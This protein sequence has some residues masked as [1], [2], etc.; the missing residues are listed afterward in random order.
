MKALI[1]VGGYGTRLRPLTLTVPKP[2]VHFC[3]KSI[4]EHQVEALVLAGVSHI[5]LAVAYQPEAMNSALQAMEK[6][7]NVRITCSREEEPL[8]TAGPIRLAKDLLEEGD[9]ENFFVFNSDVICEFPLK[10]LIDF[11]NAHGKE[12][13]LLVTKVDDPSKYGVVCSDEHGLVQKF[14]EKPKEFVGDCINAGLYIFKKSIINRIEPRPTSIEKE[15]FP[16]MS[17]ESQLF[18]LKLSGYWAD[19][20]QPKDYLRGM[21]LYLHSQATKTDDDEDA[22]PRVRLARGP[23][24]VG[25]VLVNPTSTIGKDCRIGPNVTID[26]NCHI[27][28]GVRLQNCAILAGTTIKSHAWMSNCIVGWASTIGKW[29]RIEGLTVVGEDVQVSDECYINGAFVLPHKGINAS[30]H[31]PGSII[32]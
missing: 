13:T 8:G 31:T 21:E 14:V 7:Y 16:K 6:K 12:G 27:G 2:L 3:N 15:I 1:L 20:G 9:A 22:S 18:S 28:D 26:G 5:I 17:A 19:I 23:E 30:I 10:Q 4:V 25:N 29:V 11:H 32:M 24:F